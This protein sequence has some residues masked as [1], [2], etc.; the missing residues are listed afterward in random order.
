MTTH[1]W[2]CSPD[3][4]DNRRAHNRSTFAMVEAI[5]AVAMT[6]PWCLLL[7]RVP[8]EK[9]VEAVQPE[10]HVM[11]RTRSGPSAYMPIILP[12][13]VTAAELCSAVGEVQRHMAST[14]AASVT[15]LTLP[16]K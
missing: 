7:R 8:R 10:N 13:P 9:L 3:L 2:L 6:T 11:Q 14:V 5:C 12:T 4:L 16:L 1:W 15:P